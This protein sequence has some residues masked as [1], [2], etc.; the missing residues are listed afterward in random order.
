MRR[1]SVLWILA[2]LVTLA[3]AVY[4]RAT[5][6][7]YPVRGRVAVAG[8]EYSVRLQRSHGGDGDQPVRVTIADPRVRGDVLWRRYP[9]RDPW[10]VLPMT[11]QGETLEAG[12][13]HQPPAGKLQYQLLLSTDA[14]E[15][16]AFPDVPAVTRFKGDVS[17]WI[18]APH[19]I[20]MFL[21]M[22][23]SA[24]AGLAAA[25]GVPARRSAWIAIALIGIG[26]F[27]FGPAVQKQAFDAWWA[28]V[29]YG[30]D[31]TDNKTL[32]AGLA[33]LG[34][35]VAMRRGRP[36]RGAIVFAAVTT[37]VVFAIPHSVWGSE[38]DWNAQ[39]RG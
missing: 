27:V 3:S 1:A 38:L 4:Q 30:W 35:A 23:F 16:V 21:G 11:R 5:G 2:I 29:P 26:G 28:G 32:I 39:P 10:Q 18:L 15:R 13:P 36:A 8:Q 19:V 20:A 25:A 12:L 22:L 34:A 24:H 14:G 6:P 17:P 9:T 37:L 31:L 7:T 33:W